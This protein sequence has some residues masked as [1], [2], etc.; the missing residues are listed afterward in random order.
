ME[1]NCLHGFIQKHFLHLD[2]INTMKTLKEFSA[3]NPST[4]RVIDSNEQRGNILSWD[5]RIEIICHATRK[6]YSF[7]RRAAY[8]KGLAS[9]AL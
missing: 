3:A 4:Y 6:S 8:N 7:K 5:D 9:K 1:L 2:N